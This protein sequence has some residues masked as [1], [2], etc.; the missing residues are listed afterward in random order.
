MLGLIMISA[1]ML[2]AVM[3]SIQSHN[4]KCPYADCYYIANSNDQCH[5]ADCLDADCCN[6]ENSS[7]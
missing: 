4:I 5:H 7:C 2:I 6:T 1:F 3:L